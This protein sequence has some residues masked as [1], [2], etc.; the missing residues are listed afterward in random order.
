MYIITGGAG[1]IGSNISDELDKN[2]EEFLIIDNLYSSNSYERNKKIVIADVSNYDQIK[3]IEN[4]K[5]E[6]NI[7]HLASIVNVEESRI[8]PLNTFKS[9]VMGTVNI[10]EL[11]RKTDA[12]VTIASSAAVYGEKNHMPI[13][14]DDEKNPINLY[15]YTK[16][17]EEEILFSYMKEYSLKGSALRL[18]NVYGPKMKKGPYSGVIQIFISK[19]LNNE[20]PIIYGDGRNTRDFIYVK[21]VVNAFLNAIKYKANGIYNIGTGKETSIKQLLNI[22]ENILNVYIEPIYDEPRKNDIRFSVADIEKAKNDLNWEPK[23]DLNEGLKKTI[24]FIKS[25]LL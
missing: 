12:Y 2:K 10:M 18:F 17:M 23:I 20:R 3:F 1:F 25:T 11:A 7:I 14:E 6:I 22:I 21:D 9:N 5:E 13:K 15:G 16:L 8:N 4:I 19:I 24:D